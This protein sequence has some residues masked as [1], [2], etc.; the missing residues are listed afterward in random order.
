VIR[1]L[2]LAL[3]ASACTLAVYLLALRVLARR[4]V[5]RLLERERAAFANADRKTWRNVAPM[6]L[7]AGRGSACHIA[8]LVTSELPAHL[9]PEFRTR[10]VR[11]LERG[12]VRV[13]IEVGTS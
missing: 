6:L 8:G 5:R 11:D 3:L 4:F 13:S 2:C 9:V 7:G 10:D 1:D 12:R